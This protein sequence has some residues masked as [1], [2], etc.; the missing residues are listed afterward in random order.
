MPIK[1]KRSGDNLESILSFYT[2]CLRNKMNYYD[3][4]FAPILENEQLYG[5]AKD[6]VGKHD[7][8]SFSGYINGKHF[9]KE[10]LIV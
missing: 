5:L 3:P 10:I 7:F 8:H 2:R 9:W 4:K 6:M 1:L